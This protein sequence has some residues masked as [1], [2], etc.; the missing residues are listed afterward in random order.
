MNK[1]R[2]IFVGQAPSQDTDGQAPF[3]AGQVENSLHSAVYPTLSFW[4]PL[5]SSIC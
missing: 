2:T 1:T 5:I 4:T 3:T